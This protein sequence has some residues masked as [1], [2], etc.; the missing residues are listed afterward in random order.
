[1]ANMPLPLCLILSLLSSFVRLQP[2]TEKG[3]D[4]AV[5]RRTLRQRRR[6]AQGARGW[7]AQTMWLCGEQSSTYARPDGVDGR[8][9]GGEHAAG[10]RSGTASM[11]ACPGGKDGSRPRGKHVARRRGGTTGMGARLGGEDR[12]NLRR[13]ESGRTSGRRGRGQ[14]LRGGTRSACA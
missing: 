3:R 13:A 11:G 12:L 4:A 14:T 8:G 10:R 7:A 6:P 9:L 5:A 2:R 1:M